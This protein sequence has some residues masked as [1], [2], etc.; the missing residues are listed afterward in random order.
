[1]HYSRECI[2]KIDDPN[3]GLKLYLS[4]LFGEVVLTTYE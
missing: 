3:I 2:P 1:M 4:G